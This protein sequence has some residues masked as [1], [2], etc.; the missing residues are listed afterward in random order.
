MKHITD[1]S[2]DLK[3]ANVMQLLEIL[4]WLFTGSLA[5]CLEWPGSG[6]YIQAVSFSYRGLAGYALPPVSA[7]RTRGCFTGIEE[8]L[9]RMLSQGSD[10]PGPACWVKFRAQNCFFGW[11]STH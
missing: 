4:V 2:L 1:P 9:G 6:R 5:A 7:I 3:L 11:N 8:A 10:T